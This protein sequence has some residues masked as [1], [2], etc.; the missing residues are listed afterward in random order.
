MLSRGSM[1]QSKNG[2]Q[3]FKLT[4]GIESESINFSHYQLLISEDFQMFGQVGRD[5][6]KGR[7]SFLTLV[8]LHSFFLKNLIH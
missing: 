8:F 7:D 3:F 6:S 2:I 5:E 4:K 1:V